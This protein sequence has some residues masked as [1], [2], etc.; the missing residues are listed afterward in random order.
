MIPPMKQATSKSQDPQAEDLQPQDYAASEIEQ[1]AI[2][3]QEEQSKQTV[4]EQGGDPSG[5]FQVDWTTDFAIGPVVET[6]GNAVGGGIELAG[7]AIGSAAEV[8]GSAAGAVGDAAGVIG[9]A[10]G[11]AAGAIFESLG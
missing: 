5:V 1:A 3:Q 2:A 11:S 4:R 8:A 7:N 10:A 9:E 6:V